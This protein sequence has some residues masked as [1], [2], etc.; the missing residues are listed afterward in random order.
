M[1][2]KQFII[3]HPSM[4]NS[5]SVSPLL[6]SKALGRIVL[7]GD[8]ED[9][10]QKDHWEKYLNKQYFSCGCDTGA[11]GLFFGFIGSV[12][13]SIINYFQNDLGIGSAITVIL[14]VTIVASVVGKSYGLIR[15]QKKLN[16]TIES[17]KKNW[18]VE[19][20]PVKEPW[21]CG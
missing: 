15:A 5:L 7:K 14:L 2:K 11:V 9:H 12:V 17:I 13:W 21:I 8:I 10:P 4:L 18:K 1:M 3:S 19:T 20:Q 16:K 6:R